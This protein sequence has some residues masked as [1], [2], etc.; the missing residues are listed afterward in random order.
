MFSCSINL[1]PFVSSIQAE[2]NSMIKLK[3]LP[4]EVKEESLICPSNGESSKADALELL[5]LL[6]EYMSNVPDNF[7]FWF[8]IFKE[9]YLSV[10]YPKIFQEMG[11]LYKNDGN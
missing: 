9:F 10:F 6:L 5:T 8:L 2:T 11:I 4:P 1:K 7:Q 3:N